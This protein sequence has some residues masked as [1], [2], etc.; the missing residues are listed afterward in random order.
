MGGSGQRAADPL[1][2]SGAGQRAG[3]PA[4]A[5]PVALLLLQVASGR[6]LPAGAL[7]GGGPARLP[8]P[9]LGCPRGRSLP[10]SPRTLSEGMPSPGPFL[11][12]GLSRLPSCRLPGRM[13]PG[14]KR[15]CRAHLIHTGAQGPISCPG[16]SRVGPDSPAHRPERPSPAATQPASRG[17]SDLSS[18]WPFPGGC[19]LLQTI[20]LDTAE[21][22]PPGTHRAGPEPVGLPG[23]KGMKEKVTTLPRGRPHLWGEGRPPTL[24]QPFLSL[25]LGP[26]MPRPKGFPAPADPRSGQVARPPCPPPPQEAMQ[27]EVQGLQAGL[28]ASR[29]RLGALEGSGR[30][31]P[32]PP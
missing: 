10:G 8:A 23:S 25:C 14:R 13:F 17:G 11:P 31:Q 27:L 15:P 22:G 5:P 1:L 16:P 6:P 24:A 3:L 12:P 28:E 9:G 20:S 30:P 2:G 26:P 7:A 19:L 18:P 32:G 4:Q 29:A 21:V